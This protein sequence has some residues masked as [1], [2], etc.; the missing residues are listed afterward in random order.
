VDRA[1]EEARK[2]FTDWS[3]LSHAERRPLLGDFKRT[4]VANSDHIADVICAETGKD[5]A[6]AY[7][8]DIMPS[9]GLM[10]YYARKAAKILRPTRGNLWPYPMVKRWTEYHPRGVVGAITPWNAPFFLTILPVISAI[11]A[12]NAVVAKPSELTPLSGQ[13]AADLAAEAGLPQDLVRVVHGAGDV[14]QA[15]VRAPIDLV[16]FTGSTNNGRAVAIAAAERL[17]PAILELGGNDAMVVL[18]DADLGIAARGAVWAATY[19]A[20]QICISVE[21]IYVPE[22]VYESFLAEVDAAMKD[23]AAGTGDGRDIGAI[24]DPRQLDV[25]ERQLA[26][27]VAKGAEIRWGGS[28]I[29]DGPGDFFEPTVVT[30]VDHSMELM[31][32]ETFGPIIP[33]MSV[34]DEAT[35]MQL[36]NSGRFGL[37]GSVWSGD[38]GR[39]ARFASRIESGTVAANDHLINPFIPNLSFGGIKDSGMGREGGAEG[40]RSFCYAKSITSPRFGPSTRLLLGRRWMP[41]RLGPRYWRAVAK[42]LFRW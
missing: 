35:A 36:A 9:L 6:D 26:D 12:G 29:A 7:T 39:A 33:I 14:G 20:G 18:E 30:N 32:E 34:P 28:R 16:W 19:N 38:R 27:A 42:A 13:L 17:V 11:A 24:I 15:L 8:M 23:V 10:D 21:R 5:R 31:C 4:V 1:V 2:A 3:S 22:A 37:H 40:L 41:R 25:L